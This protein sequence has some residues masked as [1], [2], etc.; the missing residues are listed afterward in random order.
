MSN[1]P[2][3]DLVEHPSSLPEMQSSNEHTDKINSEHAS[4]MPQVNAQ[5]HSYTHSFLHPL[6]Y[7]HTHH[8][9]ALL[10][11]GIQTLSFCPSI[12]LLSTFT[13]LLYFPVSLS[14]QF[15]RKDKSKGSKRPKVTEQRS[16]FSVYL[17]AMISFFNISHL[18][19]TARLAIVWNL[20]WPYSHCTPGN[21]SYRPNKYMLY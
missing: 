12:L 13:V 20:S 15:K 7:K 10:T 1:N 21:V 11:R 8:L 3:C 2:S 9:L 6:L 4:P 5:T 16:F 14:L 17:V 19:L 18:L